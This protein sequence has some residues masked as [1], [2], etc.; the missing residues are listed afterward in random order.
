SRDGFDVVA[1]C[2][3]AGCDAE[4]LACSDPCV[5]GVLRCSG[6]DVEACS[7]PLTGW[8]VVATCPASAVCDAAAPSGCRAAACAAGERR[9]DGARVERCDAA[10]AG[11]E[12]EVVCATAAL[13][14]QN[15]DDAACAA[16]ACASG[17]R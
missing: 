5:V 1:R 8:Q 6:A 9:C 4:A 3:A 16:P 7:D 12:L 10:R 14:E 11:F 17:E 2:G 15:G 13:C